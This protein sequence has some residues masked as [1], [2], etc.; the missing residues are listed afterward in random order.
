MA[1]KG[2]WSTKITNSAVTLLISS[3]SVLGSCAALACWIGAGRGWCSGCPRSVFEGCFHFA[4]NCFFVSH[5]TGALLPPWCV[6]SFTGMN[7]FPTQLFGSENHTLRE[8]VGDE[9]VE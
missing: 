3:L 1:P 4:C 5:F 6:L 2:V 9:A 7:W 8:G